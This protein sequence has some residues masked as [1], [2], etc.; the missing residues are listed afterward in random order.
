MVTKRLTQIK[1][2]EIIVNQ[3]IVQK[4]YHQTQIKHLKIMVGFRGQIGWDIKN[5]I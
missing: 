2:G 1:I 5:R 3:V 4:I